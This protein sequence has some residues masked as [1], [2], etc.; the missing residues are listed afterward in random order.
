VGKKEDRSI[1]LAFWD[2]LAPSLKNEDQALKIF[3]YGTGYF[4]LAALVEEIHE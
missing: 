2:D 1:F 4:Q 3:L